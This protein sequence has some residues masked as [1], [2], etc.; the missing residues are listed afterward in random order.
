MD[1]EQIYKIFETDK[2]LG[3]HCERVAILASEFFKDK[4]LSD[5]VIDNIYMAGLLH[6]IAKFPNMAPISFNDH[7][8]K[9][10]EDFYPIISNMI[11]KQ[12]HAKDEILEIILCHNENYDG[13][14]N[15]FELKS[16]EINIIS[17]II[18]LCDFYDTLR[19]NGES[20]DDV[21]VQIRK[22]SE[23]MFPKSII[24]P[25]IKMIIND[26]DLQFDYEQPE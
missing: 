21:T 13:T 12:L 5:E 17:M 7:E 1:I 6:D 8:A 23:K 2:K 20:H 11:A 14:S 9:N 16:K 19:M 15:L 18:H 4:E 24:T 26:K 22:N 3:D 10:F 25:F